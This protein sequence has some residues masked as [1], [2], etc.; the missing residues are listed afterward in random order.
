MA[1]N[2]RENRRRAKKNAK[3]QKIRKTLLIIA[4]AASAVLLIMNVSEINFSRFG[5]MLSGK[6]GGISAAVSDENKFPLSIESGENTVVTAINGKLAVL[7]E[8]SYS[9]IN[10]ADAKILFNDE[11]GYANPVISI[12][13]GYSVIVDQ[14]SNVYRL[15]S[16]TESIYENSSDGQIL[17]A[18]VSDTG[19]VALATVGGI[20]KSNVS[21]Y[22]KSLNRRL[23]YDISGGYVTSLAIDNRGKS[24]AFAV[25]SSENARLKTTV[26]TMSVSDTAPESEFV[27]D[28]SAVFN[29]HF[30]SHS[31]Y[32]VGEDFV[33]VIS[34]QGEETFVY[35]QGSISTVSYCYNPADNL[36]IGYGEYSGASVN[37]LSYIK[38]TGKIKAQ[39]DIEAEIKDVT[40]SGT[41]MTALTSSEIIS[42]RL[43]NG[44]EKE[45]IN[46]DDSYYEIQQMSS[47]IFGRHHSMLERING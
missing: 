11:H 5:N 35:E 21:V 39:A 25:V 24:V 26:Y 4:L 17:C 20:Q 6:D 18:D 28:G 42:F 30:A 31:L 1:T 2:Q 36:I 32:V 45:R 9:V 22:G 40:A 10:P 38:Q 29:L 13:G 41:T 33:S 34:P 44:K 43:S 46:A 8:D 47:K 27:Y 3:N 23:D 15:D 37:K 19:A 16:T 7:T 12:S 14:G